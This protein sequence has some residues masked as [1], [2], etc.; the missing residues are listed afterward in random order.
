MS[1]AEVFLTLAGALITVWLSLM[2]AGLIWVGRRAVDRARYE[3]RI[4]VQAVRLRTR[5]ALVDGVGAVATLSWMLATALIAVPLLLTV[6]P[7]FLAI[8]GL[9]LAAHIVKV[10]H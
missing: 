8:A 5:R 4:V 3:T 7:L 6:G 10:G 2:I 9:D 1:D